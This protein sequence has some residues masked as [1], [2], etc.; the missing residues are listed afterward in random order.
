M[1]FVLSTQSIVMLFMMIVST[2]AS[3]GFRKNFRIRS[4]FNVISATSSFLFVINLTGNVFAAI[5]IIGC[6]TVAIFVGFGMWWFANKVETDAENIRLGRQ[7]DPEIKQ[8]M[9]QNDR[10]IGIGLVAL[11]LFFC[12]AMIYIKYATHL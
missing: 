6:A 1:N 4:V 12:C 2:V 7:N 5:M 10:K 9:R 11:A 8:Q 3:Y